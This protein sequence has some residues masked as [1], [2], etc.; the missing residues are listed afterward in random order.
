MDIEKVYND[1]FSRI[2]N[3]KPIF[4]F[5]KY[6]LPK[7]IVTKRSVELPFIPSGSITITTIPEY[8]TFIK[9]IKNNK[10]K[11]IINNSF[12]YGISHI[13]KNNEHTQYIRDM[14][15]T[16]DILTSESILKGFNKVSDFYICLNG[17]CIHP[18]Y[19]DTYKKDTG[20]DFSIKYTL[21]DL[22]TIISFVNDAIK[23]NNV[24]LLSLCKFKDHYKSIGIFG[25]ITLSDSNNYDDLRL[26]FKINNNG[27]LRLKY[28]EFLRIEDY[29]NFYLNKE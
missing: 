10:V 8:Y 26:W 7:R 11:R 20:F 18:H 9:K 3:F 1:W 12:L 25:Y 6:L 22:D 21:S 15:N 27:S 13:K 17:L 16:K 24:S 2:L 5:D 19:L 14:Y 29:V 28:Q 23:I 4:N